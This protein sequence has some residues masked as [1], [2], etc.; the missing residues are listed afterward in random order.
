M[1]FGEA[2]VALV[3]VLADANDHRARL[4]EFFEVVAGRARL[5]RAA[6]GVILW[7]EVQYQFLSSKT[8]QAYFLAVLIQTGRW[9]WG[10]IIH[11]YHLGELGFINIS[12]RRRVHLG[13]LGA[14]T[15]HQ[16][17]QADKGWSH[18]GFPIDWPLF[19][20]EAANWQAGLL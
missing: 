10:K 15:G 8:R 4:D 19:A 13:E 1:V 3:A 11:G 16:A 9:G 18:R 6:R 12:L 5:G 20:P 14:S 7:I 2:L 17:N